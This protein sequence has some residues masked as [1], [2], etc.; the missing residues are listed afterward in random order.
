MIK[1]NII[2]QDLKKQINI[3]DLYQRFKKIYIILIL[4]LAVYISFLFA[5]KLLLRLHLNKTTQQA[6]Q[7]TKSTENYNKSVKDINDQLNYVSGI[8]ENDIRWSKLIAFLSQCANPSI[9]LSQLDISK[10]SKLIK[11]NGFSQ[12]RDALLLFKDKLE[13]SNYFSQIDF[14]LQNILQKQNINFEI[15]LKFENYEFTNI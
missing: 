10:D 1:L 14:P 3:N 12:T 9:K 2:S 8:Q 15:N 6:G 11:I 5:A 7:I 13:K 4:L